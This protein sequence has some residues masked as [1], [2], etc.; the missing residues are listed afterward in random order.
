MYQGRNDKIVSIPSY[1][2]NFLT[3]LKAV[4]KASVST[5]KYKNLNRLENSTWTNI[6]LIHSQ[7][8]GMESINDEL[9]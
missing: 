4:V 3:T 1:L 2:W 7:E 8:E 9:L 5:G 6:I